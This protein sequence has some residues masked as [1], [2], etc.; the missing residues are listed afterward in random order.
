MKRFLIIA[1]LCAV[2]TSLSAATHVWTGATSDRWSDAAN[3]EGGSPAGDAEAELLFPD[4]ATRTATVNDIASLTVRSMSFSGG[5]CTIDGNAIHVTS[6]IS[7]T[8]RGTIVLAVDLVLDGN[9]EVSVQRESL[10]HRGTISGSGGLSTSGAGRVVLQGAAPN[11]YTGGTFAGGKLVLEKSAGVAAIAGRLTIEGVVESRRGEQIPDD[12]PVVVRGFGMLQLLAFETLAQLTLERGNVVARRGLVVLGKIDARDASSIVG[13]VVVPGEQVIELAERADL[14]VD[15]PGFQGGAEAMVRTRGTGQI[16]LRGSSGAGGFAGTVVVE[17]GRVHASLAQAAIVVRGGIFDGASGG[18]GTVDVEWGTFADGAELET[19]RLTPGARWEVSRPPTIVT[20]MV[21]LGG[22][23]LAVGPPPA[24]SGGSLRLIDNRGNQPVKG[25][26]ANMAEGQIVD[27]RRISYVAGDGNDVVLT[28][29]PAVRPSMTVTHEPAW[30]LEQATVTIT[31]AVTAPNVAG[32]VTFFDG[33][34]PRAIATVPLVNGVAVLQRAFAVGPHAIRAE[35]GGHGQTL[36]AQKAETAFEVCPPLPR[37]D[38]IAP[39]AIQS[40]TAGA[41]VVL[42]GV[43][44]RPDS[45]AMMTVDRGSVPP[46]ATEYISPTELRLRYATDWSDTETVATVVV[47]GRPNGCGTSNAVTLRHTAGAPRPAST[48]SFLVRQ[49]T[50]KVT[51]GAQTVWFGVAP[52]FAALLTDTDKDGSISYTLESDLSRNVIWTVLD[53]SSRRLQVGIVNGG[54]L[55][56]LPRGMF[57]RDAAGRLTNVVVPVDLDDWYQLLW[58]RPGVGAWQAPAEAGTPW[59][60]SDDPY[61]I[62]STAEMRPLSGS[63]PP[64]AGGVVAGDWFFGNDLARRVFAGT[65]DESLGD[66]SGPG[67]LRIS[68]IARSAS[69]STP[70]GLSAHAREGDAHVR[71]TVLRTGGSEGTVSV[72]YATSDRDAVAGTDYVATS[73]T[74]TFGSGEVVGHVD[75]PLLNDSVFSG[76]PA[77]RRFDLTLSEPEGTTLE[78]DPAVT[79]FLEDDEP[80]PRIDVE[81][82]TEMEGDS[83]T[84]TIWLPVTLTGATRVPATIFSGDVPLLTFQPGETRKFI[85]FEVTGDTDAESD[86]TMP[87]SLARLQNA[88]PGTPG[89][90]RIIDDDSVTISIEDAIVNEDAPFVRLP[91]RITG[92]GDRSIQLRATIESGTASSGTD[93]AAGP[94]VTTISL[95]AQ[96][97]FEIPLTQ[98]DLLEGHEW[99]RVRLEETAGVK[100]AHGVATVTIRDDDA[101]PRLSILDSQIAEGDFKTLEVF[102]DGKI[103][104]PIQ[105]TFVVSNGTAQ[106]GVDFTEPSYVTVTLNNA[107]Q[108]GWITVKTLDDELAE[109]EETFTVTLVSA[110]GAEITRATATVT[111][112]DNDSAAIPSASIRDAVV[113]EGARAYYAISLSEPAPGPV[114][115]RFATSA[116]SATTAD[117]TPASGEA[118][119]SRG[120]IVKLI[121]LQV[122]NDSEREGDETLQITLTAA[123]GATIGRASATVT[124]E[125]D[126]TPKPPKRR[127]SL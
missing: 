66:V 121:A 61:R 101:P 55:L 108:P 44:F 74:L 13:A 82:L 8:A 118:V 51:P 59:R 112:Q 34:E 104:K 71:F 102:A 78:G 2:A 26:F 86:R 87:V 23:T 1:A 85:G 105:A 94:F 48:I 4:G 119:F 116:R 50:A 43:N 10:I 91:V 110:E 57:V 95:P 19:L 16:T 120:E 63:P 47:T 11:W 107:F 22:S 84:R 103:V 76:G 67:V 125:D 56:P 89:T 113:R 70:G 127:S 98:D 60:G 54:Q 99:F 49:G 53:F 92:R 109:A 83:G 39:A 17:G 9:V 37:I 35:Y 7:V 73:G 42:R 29:V 18:A 21:D 33:K 79:L 69:T 88:A 31:A 28:S 126:D 77:T 106:R 81:S 115:V 72:R 123:S 97:S 46:V 75:V 27:G 96:A 90:L 58:V 100:V 40:G 25:R 65:V 64:P 52:A 117:F 3:W 122:V 68:R 124:I 6:R 41:T 14:T 20:G 80:A 62:I 36:L 30:P 111:I 5:D 24:G 12:V 32:T 93:M 15:S 38:S 45:F 114:T